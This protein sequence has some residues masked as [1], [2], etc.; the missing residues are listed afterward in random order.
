MIKSSSKGPGDV[1]GGAVGGGEALDNFYECE[2]CD[3]FPEFDSL[4][5]LRQHNLVTHGVR[6]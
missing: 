4:A 3:G 6:G 1:A 5:E 2:L